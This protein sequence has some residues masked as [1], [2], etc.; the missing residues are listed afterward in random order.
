MWT[1]LT[2]R[3]SNRSKLT[4]KLNVAWPPTSNS[5]VLIP[6][7]PTMWVDRPNRSRWSGPFAPPHCRLQ[8]YY[9][10]VRQPTPRRYS[11]PHSSCCLV[12]SLSPP[13]PERQYRS[14]PTTFHAA[15]ADQARVT[16]MPETTWPIRSA[17]HLRAHVV[18]VPRI[19]LPHPLGPQQSTGECSPRSCPRS[20]KRP[21]TGHEEEP[22]VQARSSLSTKAG[23]RPSRPRPR[24][25][26]PACDKA[27]IN[28]P[29]SFGGTVQHNVGSPHY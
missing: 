25:R 4:A 11:A 7:P 17:R 15:A 23:P 1:R 29:N 20:P 10:P 6:I 13:Q 27:S 28:E 21:T 26:R 5:D 18:H 8:Q 19:H 24:V 14:G 9:E 22:K 3:P 12:V 2:H 16:F